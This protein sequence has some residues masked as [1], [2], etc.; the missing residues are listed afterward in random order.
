MSGSLPPSS[1]STAGTWAYIADRSRVE[2]PH[3]CPC[4]RL[5]TCLCLCLLLAC[6]GFFPPIQKQSCPAFLQP[7]ALL[8]DNGKIKKH[9]SASPAIRASA[10][11]GLRVGRRFRDPGPRVDQRLTPGQRDSLRAAASCF[12]LSLFESRRRGRRIPVQGEG[13]LLQNRQAFCDGV[14]S[15]MRPSAAFECGC[16]WGSEPRGA[17]PA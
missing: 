13:P 16:G 7:R 5:Q 9:W 11:Q 12:Y 14:C 15:D 10:L 6:P 2:R 17:D 1:S 8:I 3:P 4:L